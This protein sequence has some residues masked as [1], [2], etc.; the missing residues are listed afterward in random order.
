MKHLELTDAYCEFTKGFH[1]PEPLNFDPNAQAISEF[2]FYHV[3][4]IKDSLW[5]QMGPFERFKRIPT[6][7]LLQD[8]IAYYLKAVLPQD[9]F[10]VLLEVKV[11]KFQP[12]ILIQ[13]NG[14]NLFILEIKT[15]IGWDRG[16]LNGAIQSRINDLSET[17]NIASENVIF[18]F[19]S[20]W[21]VSK[22]FC[23]LY[24]KDNTRVLNAELQF[25]YNRIRPLFNGEDPFY[26]KDRNIAQVFDQEEIFRIAKRNVV[27]P[28]E[29]TINEILKAA[30]L[31]RSKTHIPLETTF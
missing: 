2:I 16:S 6:S 21:N 17:F 29:M 27:V 1:Y 7:D 9:E 13:Y 30:E 19:Q 11:G 25:P 20:P 26:Y 8:I 22:A 3:F 23:E 12:D 10:K 4:R 5:K 24:W 31:V 14:K 18:I 15:T 28:I